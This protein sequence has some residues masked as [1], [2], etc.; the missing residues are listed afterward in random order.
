M[1]EYLELWQASDLLRARLDT[2][3][4]TPLPINFENDVGVQ[5][6]EMGMIYCEVVPI[7]A[8]QATINAPGQREFRDKAVFVVIVCVPRGSLASQAEQWASELRSLFIPDQFADTQLRIINRAITKVPKP[9]L[10]SRWH[11]VGLAV[12]FTATRIE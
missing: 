7:A 3:N 6:N 10:A 4:P 9:D 11:T 1:A 2:A 8:E 5:F 12:T